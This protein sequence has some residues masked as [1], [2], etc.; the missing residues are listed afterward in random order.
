[1]R[2]VLFAVLFVSACSSSENTPPVAPPPKIGDVESFAEVPSTEG[3]AFGNGTLYVGSAGAIHRIAADGSAQKWID[4]PGALGIAV[5]ADGQLLVCGKGDGELGK[6]E[7]PGVIWK[8]ALDGNKSIF[9]GPSGSVGFKQPNFVAIAPD[10]SIVFSDSAADR[11]YRAN[12]DGSSP[13]LITD[14]IVYPNGL[15][16]SRDGKVLYVASWKTKKVLSLA[17]GT[18]GSYGPPAIAV[19]G[20]ENVDGLAVGASGDLYLIANGLGILRARDEKFETVAPG[21]N[22]KLAAN[23]AFATGTH[24]TG[25]LYVTNLIGPFVSRV[26]VGESGAPLPTR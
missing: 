6:S 7:Q 17:R 21:S 3:I 22:F 16:F 23:G 18:D 26:Y 20:A 12:A 11:L 13:A 19:D 25:W 15:A 2:G 24:G 8:I 9:V 1:V 5:R 14:T 10:D 4:V